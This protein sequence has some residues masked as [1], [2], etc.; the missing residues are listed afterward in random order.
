MRVEGHHLLVGVAHVGLERGDD[1]RGPHDP[2]D[3]IAPEAPLGVVALAVGDRVALGDA[4]EGHHRVPEQR[5]HRELGLEREV[6]AEVGV[7]DARAQEQ[8]RGVHRVAGD[9][10]DLRAHLEAAGGVVALGV[11]GVDGEALHLGAEIVEARHPRPGEDPRP[12]GERPG[13]RHEAGVALG[14]RRAAD[15]AGPQPGAA[16]PVV[17]HHL[18]LEAQ[19]LGAL[20]EEPVGLVHLA[21]VDAARREVLEGPGGERR[22]GRLGELGEPQA[23]PVGEDL[24]PERHHVA[25]VDHPAAAEDV[26]LEDADGQVVGG[27]PAAVGVELIVHRGVALGELRPREIAPGLEDEHLV[28]GGGEVPGGGGAAVARAHHADLGG[29]RRRRGGAAA[30][31]DGSRAHFWGI[32]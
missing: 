24:G 18:A 10:D 6:A 3:P 25:G 21:L 7:V 31:G 13:E 9:D 2:L 5:H 27:A 15:E 29:D 32:P 26:S 28:P 17:V 1:P 16:H 8:R 22:Q 11:E 20:P 4:G 12:V 14:V 19:G 23:P 30:I